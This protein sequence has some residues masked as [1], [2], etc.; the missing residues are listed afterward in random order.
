MKTTHS[1]LII[2]GLLILAFV[3]SLDAQNPDPATLM[4]EF[5]DFTLISHEGDSVSL[6][7][8]KRKNVLLV[9][10]RGHFF[11]GWCR[12]CHYQ[13]AELADLQV[14]KDIEKKY[15]LK[16]LF[17]L[18][19]PESDIKE[20][21]E[22]FPAQ[23][24][25]IEQYKYPAE[26]RRDNERLMAFSKEMQQAMPKDFIFDEE[27]PAPL[28]FP[29]L[30]DTDH[31]FSASL[32]LYNNDWGGYFEQNEPTI[33]ILDKDGVIQFKYKSQVTLD[34]PKADYLLN[35]IEKVMN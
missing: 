9:F 3:K 27:N 34:R 16:I 22:A 26:D 21:T 11:D 14:R 30:A 12:A 2:I 7:D 15:N 13:Y 18:P 20:W 24:K 35:Y 6:H 32:K 29:V 17:I 10:P 1:I 33:F 23:M 4:E 25:I 5:P 19:Y 8:Y 31:K 28:P